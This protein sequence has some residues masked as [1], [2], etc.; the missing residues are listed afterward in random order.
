MTT[1]ELRAASVE[2]VSLHA[3]FAPLFGRTEARAH[4]LEYLRGLLSP[5]RR[6]SAEPMA[7]ALADGR[8]E[9][10]A[11][12]V[13]LQRFLTRSPWPASRVQQEIQAVFATQLVPSTATWT[14]GTVGVL[15]ASDFVKQGKH[16]AGVAPQHSGRLGKVANCQVGVFLVGVTP[17]GCALLD[18]QLYLPKS[19]SRARR[20]RRQT[21][22]P[23]GTRFRT[24]PALAAELVRRTVAAGH[25]HFDWLVA[26]EDYGKDQTLLQTLEARS[27]RYVFE[28]PTT[29]L[30][31]RTDPAQE[32]PSDAEHRSRQPA[33]G[34]P[35]LSVQELAAQLPAATWQA[36]QV[37][38]GAK[39]PLVFQFAALRVW[40][41]RR[42]RPGPPVWLLLRRA[43]EKGAPIK[44]YLSNADA[45]TP[46]AT[47]AGAMCCRWRV[48]EWFEDSKGYLGMAHYEARSW[49]SWHHHMSLVALAHLYVTLVRQQLKKKTPELTLD[50]TVALL[51]AVLPLP[52]LTPERALQLLDYYLQRNRVAQ[53]SHAKTWKRKH[54]K[55][56]YQAPL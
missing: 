52:I 51:Q 49:T 21:R 14:L 31:W 17:A 41:V 5:L 12:I 16:S 40:A 45:Q 23:V 8:D 35:V 15:D 50:R 1:D 37:R 44:Y 18:H 42:R 27:Q 55:V 39:G 2:L 53:K 11:P 25:V 32:A 56:K 34:G 54:K 4:S 38:D 7:L 26:D 46:L 43:V 3:R 13:P 22:V 6:K 19:W 47:L 20:L 9:G 33:G 48:D 28:V 30:V 10:N 24:K 36:L 29:T